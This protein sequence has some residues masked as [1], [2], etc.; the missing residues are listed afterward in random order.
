MNTQDK[1]FAITRQAWQIWIDAPY[2]VEL[3]G[4]PA[5][6]AADRAAAEIRV[7]TELERLLGGPAGVL[8]AFWENYGHLES[9]EALGEDAPPPPS[10]WADAEAAARAAGFAGM[11][12]PPKATFWLSFFD[13]VY[14][15]PESFQGQS[16]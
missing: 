1:V 13:E 9:N 5:L 3:L 10:T 7:A 16:I 11:V 8:S 14:E 15:R 4:W 12:Q 6:P 2:F